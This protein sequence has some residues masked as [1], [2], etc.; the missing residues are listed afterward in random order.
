MVRVGVIIVRNSVRVRV[1]SGLQMAGSIGS[2]QGRILGTTNTQDTRDEGCMLLCVIY[3][4]SLRN[5]GVLR[6]PDSTHD[7]WR[8]NRSFV[9]VAPTPWGRHVCP[10]LLQMAGHGGHRE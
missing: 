8:L 5:Y 4:Y 9:S 7:P 3:P 10:R 2:G 1:S 6:A